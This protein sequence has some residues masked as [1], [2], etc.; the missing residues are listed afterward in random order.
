MSEDKIFKRLSNIMSE[1]T[2]IP[3]NYYKNSKNNM[4][5][6]P[7][8]VC[9]YQDCET[10]NFKLTCSQDVWDEIIW[11][12]RAIGYRYKVSWRRGHPEDRGPFYTSRTVRTIW[13]MA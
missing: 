6:L 1:K 13:Q 7:S 8:V 4:L 11:Y 9:V 12:K 5:E 3:I 10:R 2:L